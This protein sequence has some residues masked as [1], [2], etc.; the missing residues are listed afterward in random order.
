MDFLKKGVEAAKKAGNKAVTQLKEVRI[1]VLDV[2]LYSQ[3][4]VRSRGQARL[5]RVYVSEHPRPDVNE[6]FIQAACATCKIE[7]GDL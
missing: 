5:T 2:R 1:S 7:C 4:S 6:V 3:C